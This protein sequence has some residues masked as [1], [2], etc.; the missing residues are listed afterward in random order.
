MTALIRFYDSTND[1]DITAVTDI[2]AYHV[3]NGRGSFEH[4]AP[5]LHDM[6]ARFEAL[7]QGGYPILIAEYEGQIAGYAYAGPHKARKGYDGTV[8]DSVYIAPNAISK[9]VGAALLSA[10]IEQARAGG[11]QQMMAVIGDSANE[12][13]IGLH[14]AL[15]F[16]MIG[17]AKGIGYKFGTYLDVTYMQKSLQ[18]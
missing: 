17:T 7:E 9:G 18:A 1:H 11:Y 4:E 6:K 12:A 5:S 14:T 15:G 16:E 10:L 3:L 13:S 8:E 2:Y